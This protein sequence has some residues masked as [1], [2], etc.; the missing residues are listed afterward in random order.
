MKQRHLLA[1]ALLLTTTACTSDPEPSDPG[2]TR[3]AAPAAGEGQQLAM[4]ALAPAYS[5]IWLC[6]VKEFPGEG[7]Q[8]V[9]SVESLQSNTMHHMDVMALAYADVDLELGVHDCNDLY[10]EH[11]ELMEDGM[12]IY[13]AQAADQKILLPEGVA[14]PIPGGIKVMQE[15]HYV[16]TS[17]QDEKVYSDINTYTMPKADVK[18]TIWG[19][20]VRDTHLNIPPMSEHQEWTRCVMSEE[21]QLLF[22]ASHTHQ[23][24]RSVTVRPF[25]GKTAGDQMYENTNWESPRL[26][27]FTTQKMMIDKGQGFEFTCNFQNSTNEMVNWGFLA[28]DEMCQIALVYTP[29]DADISCDVVE[30]SDGVLDGLAEK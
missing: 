12:I 7:M 14:A 11:A 10:A 5:E 4:E 9:H 17:A 18:D 21:V 29:G 20:V 23:L 25:D 6:E 26:E 22:L 16:N 2:P 30:S 27:D 8:Y 28:E 3:L 15:I 13:G 24:G 1:I 19:T